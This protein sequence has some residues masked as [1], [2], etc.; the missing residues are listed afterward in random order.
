MLP[1]VSVA[2]VPSTR[3]TID[4]RV[5]GPVE[6]RVGGR[7]VGIGPRR[8]RLVLA[9]LALEANR[10]VSVDRLVELAWP[11]GAPR[12]AVHAVQVL[13]SRLR[14]VLAGVSGEIDISTSG[15]GYMLRADP[16]CVDASRFL[17]LLEQARTAVDDAHRV[18]LLTEALDLWSGPALSGAAPPE[19]RERL[20]HSLEEARLAANRDLIESRLA[21][22]EHERLILDLER[23]TPDHPYDEQLHRQLMLA[24]YRAGRQA[25]ALAVYRQLRDTLRTEHGIDPSQP[26]RA[27]EGAILRQDPDLDPAPAR[28]TLAAQPPVPAQLPPALA[29][30]AGRRGTIERLDAIVGA[31]AEAKPSAAAIAVV[32]G[33]AGVGKTTLAVQWAHRV[34]EHFLDGQLYVNLRGF[35]PAGS[36]LEPAAALRA[37]LDAFAVPVARIPSGVDAQT[38]LYRSLMAGRRILVV[39]DNARDA[40]QVRPLLPGAPGCLTIVTSR[41]QLTSLVAT[42]G[43]HCVTLDLLTDTEAHDLLSRRLGTD[44]VAAEPD[45]ISEIIDRCARLPLALAIAA[46]RAATRTAFPLTA[47]AGELRDASASAG[48]DALRAGDAATDVRAVLSWSYRSVSADAARLF[49]L[50]GQHPGPEFTVAAAASAAGLD[51]RSVLGSLTELVG[52]HLIAESGPGRYAVHDLL[53]A[54]AREQAQ[55][56]DS[57]DERRAAIRRTL[58]HYLHAAYVAARLLDS[59]RDPI[60]LPSP[61]PGVTFDEPADHEQAL[62]WFDVERPVLLAAV[63]EAAATGFDTYVWQLAWTL[64]DVLERRGHWDDFAA[65]QRAALAAAYRLSDQYQ[66]ARAHRTLARAY[67]RLR[68]FAEANTH[69]RQAI[70]LSCVAGDAVG[71]ANGHLNLAEV[72]ARQGCGAE[73]LDHARRARDLFEAA[74]HV[75]GLTLALNAVGWFHAQLGEY[76]PAVDACQHA[77]RLMEE[78]GDRPGQAATWD[79]LGY[80]HHRAGRDAE[81]VRCYE[82]AVDLYRELGDRYEEATSLTNLGDA[83][84]ARDVDRARSAWCRALTILDELGHPDADAIRARLTRR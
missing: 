83:H 28:V 37:F 20:C 77:L 12:T 24:L 56:T 26:V 51:I 61:L 17:A 36:A 6:L 27:L 66:Q 39:L 34:A 68:N 53:R 30:F 58:D 29:V 52:G 9:V 40:D 15:T 41:N 47:L 55:R 64:V 65:T 25:D 72:C 84:V 11:E 8:L 82:R 10:L 1:W 42:E 14:G 13:V 31:D 71:Q 5:L 46:A 69:L 60:T 21:L 57:P 4:I 74:D 38:A 19:T 44:R 2:T 18:A 78:T 23:L 59:H 7:P 16:A 81:A 45:A 33:T 43:A 79:S 48:L 75:P 22:G 50:L 62:S 67:L 70:D 54:F 3:D 76:R 49:R 80:A 63:E 73:A 35:D 32:S